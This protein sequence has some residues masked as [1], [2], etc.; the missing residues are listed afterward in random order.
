MM[1][2]SAAVSAALAVAVATGCQVPVLQDTDPPAPAPAPS[3]QTADGP[4]GI[5]GTWQLDWSDDFDGT[6]VDTSKWN[7]EE[8]APNGAL[9]CYDPEHVTESD[10]FLHL[11]LELGT[12]AC[13]GGAVVRD[14]ASG[15]VSARRAFTGGAFEARINVPLTGSQVANWP[16]WWTVA[17]PAEG[18]IDWWEGGGSAGSC[19][20]VHP[21]PADPAGCAVATPGWHTFGGVW[22]SGTGVD[23]YYDGSKV[24][25][26]PFTM[27]SAEYPVLDNATAAWAPVMAPT[28]LQVD[29]VRHWSP[30]APAS[31]GAGDSCPGAASSRARP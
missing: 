25:T 5:P 16:A 27:T 3:A 9:N 22:T 2:R 14:Y 29:Y 13:A 10:G 17:W 26:L 18:E 12:A 21:E 11:R 7:I 28:D 19:W 24:A 31:P 1:R 23:V 8:H 20:S 6:T 15:S 30:C 4:L